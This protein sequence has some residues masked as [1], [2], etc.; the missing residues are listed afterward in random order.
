MG[1]ERV[2]T[3]FSGLYFFWYLFAFFEQFGDFDDFLVDL[4]P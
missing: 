1:D 3:F 2:G 4:V